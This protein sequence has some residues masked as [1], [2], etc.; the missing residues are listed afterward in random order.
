MIVM[1]IQTVIVANPP[2]PSIVILKPNEEDKERFMHIVPIWIGVNEATQI[3]I[4]LEKARFSRPITHDLFL[5]TLTNLDAIIDHVYIY[6]LVGS[7]FYAK[8][9][10]RQHAR[11]IEIDARPSDALAL[12][13][14]QKAPI[15]MANEVFDKASFAYSFNKSSINEEDV[16]DFHTFIESLAPEDFEA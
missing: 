3:G 9:V 13:L 16:N 2:A 10:L 15:F 7:T 4:A 8:L 14:R 6:K 5:D 11:L 1:K 12:A